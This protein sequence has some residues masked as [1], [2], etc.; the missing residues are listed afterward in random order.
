[1]KPGSYSYRVA[2]GD[3]EASAELTLVPDRRVEASAQDFARVESNVSELTALMNELL[4]HLAAIRKSRRQVEEL[5]DDHPDAERLQRSGRSAVDRL[6]AWER[7]VLQVDFETYEDEDNLPPRLV[8]QVRHLLDVIDDAG[9]PVA[10]GALERLGDLKAEW[11]RLR[12]ELDEIVSSDLATVN[13]WARESSVPHV[14][15]PR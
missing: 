9:P 1:M 13:E 3:A 7:T 10:A 12:D 8:K 4:D 15:P 14:A 2:I 11:A 5:L 6:T